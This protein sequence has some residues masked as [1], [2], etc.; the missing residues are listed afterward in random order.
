MAV[1]GAK[2]TLI[3]YIPAVDGNYIPGVIAES[4]SNVLRVIRKSVLASKLSR[5]EIR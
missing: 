3:K 4:V 5:T 2:E 1:S